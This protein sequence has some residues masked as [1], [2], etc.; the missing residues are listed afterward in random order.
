MSNKL[1]NLQLP[2]LYPA[3]DTISQ[4]FLN[5]RP[6]TLQRGYFS[7]RPWTWMGKKSQLYFH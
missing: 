3:D 4:I 2:V 7:E 6:R 1:T 5:W